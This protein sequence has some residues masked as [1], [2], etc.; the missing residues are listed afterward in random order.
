[1]RSACVC[2]FPWE[3]NSRHYWKAV[4]STQVKP[5]G[6]GHDWTFPLLA[7][8]FE[9]GLSWYQTGALSLSHQPSRQHSREDFL[10]THTHRVLEILK[11][12]EPLDLDFQK[13]SR[14]KSPLI[15]GFWKFSKNKQVSLKKNPHSK[16]GYLTRYLIFENHDSKS[17]PILHFL[18]TTHQ[19][20]IYPTLTHWF[21]LWKE[22]CTTLSSVYNNYATP[23]PLNHS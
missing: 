22:N 4:G 14:I 12:K 2:F 18:R 19:G 20:S 8:K 7:N 13:K 3:L 6:R 9:L 15:L 23:S 16:V 5:D 1:M 21:I 17:K 10:I 11:I